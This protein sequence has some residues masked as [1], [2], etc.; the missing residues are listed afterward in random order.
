[1]V[2]GFAD[3]LL[4]LEKQ[5]IGKIRIVQTL[6]PHVFR[7]HLDALDRPFFADGNLKC[8]R[9]STLSPTRCGPKSSR[10]GSGRT[11]GCI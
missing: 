10:A 6:H 5:T 2:V 8:N 3:A 1:M 9:H 11:D 4:D 7:F